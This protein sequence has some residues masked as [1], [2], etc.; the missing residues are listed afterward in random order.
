MPHSSVAFSAIHNFC[1]T[2]SPANLVGFCSHGR[3]FVIYAPCHRYTLCNTL[4][5]I[6]NKVQRRC[7]ICPSNAVVM[8]AG[9]AGSFMLSVA[10]A[11]FLQC[12]PPRCKR[13]NVGHAGSR[14]KIVGVVW[15]FSKKFA[16]TKICRQ[17]RDSNPRRETLVD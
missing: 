16:E 2:L 14:S 15:G 10:F 13:E 7:R 17:R 3:S 5:L 9:C 6:R 4:K 1:S 12:T 8:T 11:V